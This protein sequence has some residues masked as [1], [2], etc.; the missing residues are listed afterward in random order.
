MS[1]KTYSEIVNE[2]IQRVYQL[3]SKDENKEY[4]NSII[5]SLVT[6]LVDL[7]R[8]EKSPRVQALPI[9]SPYF[10]DQIFKLLGDL[11]FV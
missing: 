8:Q 1:E 10:L 5:K 4:W 2:E 3:H 7:E 9:D 6:D 11:G